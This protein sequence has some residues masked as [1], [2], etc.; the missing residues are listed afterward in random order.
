MKESEIKLESSLVTAVFPPLMMKVTCTWHFLCCLFR[1][2]ILIVLNYYMKIVIVFHYY[3]KLVSNEQQFLIF[4]KPTICII[5]QSS[6]AFMTS[7]KPRATVH[8]SKK[9]NPKHFWPPWVARCFPM[10]MNVC[11]S[12]SSFLNILQPRHFLSASRGLQN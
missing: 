12:F 11:A 9:F 2:K 7:W 6:T 10:M 4:T 8:T 3:M 5:K 1:L